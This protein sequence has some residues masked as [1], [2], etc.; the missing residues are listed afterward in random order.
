MRECDVAFDQT[1]DFL[2][3]MELKNVTHYE[4][5][6]IAEHRAEARRKL[7]RANACA[8][9]YDV[10]PTMLWALIAYVTCRACC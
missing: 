10:V 4:G 1:M 5:K 6:T 2:E 7:A 9:V 3:Y 8:T